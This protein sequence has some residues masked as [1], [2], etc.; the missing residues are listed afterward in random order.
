MFLVHQVLPPRE[1]SLLGGRP[2]QRCI[3]IW[4]Q[5]AYYFN[6]IYNTSIM[7]S[8]NSLVGVG[9]GT[10]SLK[11]N[12]SKSHPIHIH[13]QAFP[14]NLFWIALLYFIAIYKLPAAVNTDVILLTS[15]PPIFAARAPR[16]CRG[17]SETRQLTWVDLH[18]GHLIDS[19]STFI[20]LWI[21]LSIAK[22][23]LNSATP[24]NA[25]SQDRSNDS[26]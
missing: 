24:N 11:E 25:F 16:L 22:S 10:A 13:C 8:F 1:L 7:Y 20:I 17:F 5:F 2:V 3:S 12:R 18:S 14:F 9:V 26:V 4:K 21:F 19:S 23:Y 6:P 15:F